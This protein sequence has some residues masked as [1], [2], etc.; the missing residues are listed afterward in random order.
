MRRL[1]TT[2]PARALAVLYRPIESIQ[3]D[4][5]NPRGNAKSSSAPPRRSS[6]AVMLERAGSSSSNWTGRF[7]FC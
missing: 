4:A 5:G 6:H 3:P 2:A 1:S 7:V